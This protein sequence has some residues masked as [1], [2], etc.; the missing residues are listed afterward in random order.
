M[1]IGGEDG[2][3]PS[4][5]F[6]NDSA[7][8]FLWPERCSKVLLRH[9]A[10]DPLEHT[11]V[12]PL[13]LQLQEEKSGDSVEKAREENEVDLVRAIQEKGK[14]RSLPSAEEEPGTII[15]LGFPWLI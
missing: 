10:L 12:S 3:V 6:C 15:P 7:R 11:K 5:S 8:G 1:L 4:G 2:R 9:L 14:T 13:I